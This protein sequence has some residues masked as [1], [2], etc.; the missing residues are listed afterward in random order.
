MQKFSIMVF[1]DQGQIDYP[2]VRT[3]NMHQAMD[4]VLIDLEKKNLKPTQISAINQTHVEE[5]AH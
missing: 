3:E 5:I 4:A 1:T 2:N